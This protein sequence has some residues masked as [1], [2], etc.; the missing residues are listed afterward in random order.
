M[1]VNVLGDRKRRWIAADIRLPVSRA[2]VRSHEEC[3]RWAYLAIEP[4]LGHLYHRHAWYDRWDRTLVLLEDGAH[5]SSC[6]DLFPKE[7][8]RSAPLS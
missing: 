2:W 1:S 5:S 8:S 4:D 6:Y 3:G 7:M